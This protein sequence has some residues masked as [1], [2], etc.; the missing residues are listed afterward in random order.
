MFSWHEYYQLF[1]SMWRA[2]ASLCDLLYIVPVGFRDSSWCFRS[3][4][5]VAV[6]VVLGKLRDGH[7][8]ITN[9]VF[10]LIIM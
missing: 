3:Q 7:K 2:L 5:P 4:A 10:D 1:D 9:S 6:R 8:K